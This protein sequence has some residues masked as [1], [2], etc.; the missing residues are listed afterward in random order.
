MISIDMTETVQTN[1]NVKPGSISLAFDAL[2]MAPVVVLTLKSS[3]A[4]GK[5]SIFFKL[6]NMMFD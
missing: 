4:L 5:A 6:S 2:P 3:K 1:I